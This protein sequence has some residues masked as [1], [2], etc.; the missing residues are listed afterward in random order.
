MEQMPDQKVSI[1]EMPPNCGGT[2]ALDNMASDYT[3]KKKSDQVSR[4]V[5]LT[6]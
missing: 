6:K 3:P 4:K 1:F 2:I 5:L